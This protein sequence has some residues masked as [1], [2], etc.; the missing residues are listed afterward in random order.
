LDIELSEGR[1]Y[2]VNPFPRAWRGHAYAMD[3]LPILNE[4]KQLEEEDA[5]ELGLRL[6]L[7]S[8]A[9]RGRDLAAYQSDPDIFKVLRKDIYKKIIADLAP[10]VDL[11]NLDQVQSVVKE[12]FIKI[13]SGEN[14]VLSRAEQDR[15]F[16]AVLAE[17]LDKLTK[18]WAK[19]VPEAGHEFLARKIREAAEPV[20]V[21]IT[22]PVS[23]LAAALAAEPALAAKIEEVVWMGGALKVEGNVRDYEHDGSAEWNAYWD[24]PA[25]YRL[26][27][28]DMPLTLFPLDA[29]NQV[30]VTMEFLHR[31]AQQRKYPLSDL[32][33]QCWALTVGVIPAYEYI[34]HMWDTLTT[35]YL[36]APDCIEFRQVRT[37]VI[38]HGPSA[39]RIQ[40]VSQGGK[41][42]RAAETVQVE[43]FYNYLL[44]L[45]RR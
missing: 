26:W 12:K 7:T 24:P 18:L 44:E 6:Q 22:G 21:L 33:G 19:P 11:A 45:F 15:L 28:F 43:K 13:L 41:V 27:Q 10:A 16:E 14:I 8:P 40:E 9:Y 29:T 42:I 25:T 36:G 32:A 34:Y 30:R 23:N 35:G 37:E 38:A 17:V 1:L 39:G 4:L 2:G 20:T 5:D 3:A 31:L